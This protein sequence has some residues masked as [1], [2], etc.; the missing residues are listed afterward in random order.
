MLNQL[1]F[2]PAMCSHQVIAQPPKR[3]NVINRELNGTCSKRYLPVIKEV[4]TSHQRG[5][6]QSSL[7]CPSQV[8][9]SLFENSYRR[10]GFK[11]QE[12]IPGI[13]NDARKLIL[14]GFGHSNFVEF[15]GVFLLRI[16]IY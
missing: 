5:I 3:V 6:Y 7:L 8:G 15:D 16:K 13:E 12:M 9:N 14:Q 10:C 1:D 2:W 11:W 4:F